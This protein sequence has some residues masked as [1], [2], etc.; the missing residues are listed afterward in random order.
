MKATVLLFLLLAMTCIQC[1]AHE[2]VNR[3]PNA[4][5]LRHLAL[6][7]SYTK[8]QGVC[9]TC[10]FPAQLK[11]SLTRNFRPFDVY[12]TTLIAET[13]WTTTQLKTA[14]ASRNQNLKYDFV[15]LLIGVNNQYQNLPFSIYE[16]EFP[17][18]VDQAILAVEGNRNRVFVLSIP[19]YAYTPFGQGNSN[20]SQISNEI[21]QYNTFAQNYCEN[22]AIQFIDITSLSRTGLTNP[23][24]VASDG[25]H[26]STQAYS[27]ITSLIL[28]SV[29]NLID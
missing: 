1:D 26:L 22:N 16:S 20:S 17:Q 24:L 28:P 4:K 10:N 29:K 6:G 12:T 15:T 23:E 3:E 13:G 18:L 7:D 5:R 9:F 2:D 27:I 8:G 11:D 21:D 25:L 19:D 14:V